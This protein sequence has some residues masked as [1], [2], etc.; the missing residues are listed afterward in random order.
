MGD[1]AGVTGVTIASSY[2]TGGSVIAPAVGEALGLPVL[3][4]AIS[5]QV[6]GRLDVTRAEAETARRNKSLGDRF[7]SLLA[8]LAGGVLGA[9]TDAA[10]GEAMPSMDEAEAFREQAEQVMRSALA[11]GAVILG[12]A[13][14]AAFRHEPGVLRVR[15]FGDDSARLRHAMGVE[16][17]DEP[18]AQ[19]R[20]REVD[21]AR[22]QYVRRLYHC[23]IDDP[24]LFTLQIDSTALVIEACVELIVTA[25]RGLLKGDSRRLSGGR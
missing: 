8:P 12:R 6:A 24:A 18:T 9:G 22:E 14:S 11:D 16:Q 25:Y 21:G 17:I 1:S 3:D 2:G 5:V 13:G 7:L 4:R 20:M 19:Q 10:P 15:L 23:S